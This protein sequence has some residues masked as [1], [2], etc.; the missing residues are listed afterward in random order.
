MSL[1]RRIAFAGL[2]A[3]A[4]LGAMRA[5]TQ[6]PMVVFAEP[7]LHDALLAAGWL[8]A[9]KTLQPINYTFGPSFALAS[10]IGAGAVADVL[11]AIDS[12]MD[13]LAKLGLIA[14]RRK[15]YADRLALIAPATS[16]VQLHVD[17][18][19]KLAAAPG[20]TR[21]ALASDRT[22]EGRW[23]RA[24]LAQLKSWEAIKDH[25]LITDSG[26]ATVAK[27]ATGQAS[28]GIVFASEA[29]AEPRV[30]VA[31]LFP[32]SSHAPI[33]YAGAV[34]AVSKN[35][36]AKAFLDELTEPPMATAFRGFDRP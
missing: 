21:L 34:T 33:V 4:G 20:T 36:N 25:L 27:V 15:L 14:A 8:F 5:S 6:P 31:H 9:A 19:M 16:K 10:Q 26:A 12:S 23:S 32:L 35:P 7:A 1:T 2:A 3:G 11:I 24:A 22:T 13:N 29:K 18:G 30:R 17:M 28:W